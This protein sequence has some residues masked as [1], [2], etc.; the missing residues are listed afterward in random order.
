MARTLTTAALLALLAATAQATAQ[1]GAIS[2]E[3]VEKRSTHVLNTLYADTGFTCTSVRYPNPPGGYVARCTAPGQPSHHWAIT[4]PKGESIAFTP[5][6]EAARSKAP[7]G[8]Q[9]FLGHRFV[10]QPE[11][12]PPQIPAMRAFLVEYFG[13][14]N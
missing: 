14:T 12:D 5:L 1:T 7:G 8:G 9:E 11:T 4:I 2:L 6:N 10:R 13:C 3:M